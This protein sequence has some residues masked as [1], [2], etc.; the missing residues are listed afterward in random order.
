VG[1]AQVPRAALPWR[2]YSSGG[3]TPDYDVGLTMCAVAER[4][5]HQRSTKDRTVRSQQKPASYRARGRAGSM[6]RLAQGVG[7]G[8]VDSIGFGA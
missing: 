1:V 4:T 2:A 7:P 3:K 8:G 6:A 5:D